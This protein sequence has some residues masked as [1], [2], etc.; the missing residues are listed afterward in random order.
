MS[1]ALAPAPL[2]TSR[3]LADR[4]LTF[5]RKRAASIRRTCREIRSKGRAH[6]S[7]VHTLRRACRAC[8]S[9]LLLLAPAEQPETG[10]LRRRLRRLRRAAGAVRDADVALSLT[11]D[12]CAPFPPKELSA[13]RS[14]LRALRRQRE[15]E[16]LDYLDRRPKGG[17]ARGLRETK[18]LAAQGSR[19]L[20]DSVRQLQSE[21]LAQAAAAPS[22]AEALHNLRLAAKRLVYAC[23]VLKIVWPT[24]E[25]TRGLVSVLGEAQDWDALT[26]LALDLEPQAP[27]PGRRR[28]TLA[29]R[30]QSIAAQRLQLAEHAVA[31][32]LAA[33]QS[34]SPRRPVQQR[35]S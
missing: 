34:G 13:F 21:V 28:G 11:R 27:R 20:M 32:F 14:G 26:R 7:K 4:P 35:G 16:L 6:P 8:E 22:D 23:R 5:L 10:L 17:L 33:A 25:S 15:R 31:R 3:R 12:P 1:A 19:L 2:P 24:V 9:A 30:F 18:R 29:S